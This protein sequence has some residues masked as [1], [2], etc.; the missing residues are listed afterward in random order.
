MNPYLKSSLVLALTGLAALPPAAVAESEDAFCEVR[1]QGERAGN[2]SGYCTV[3]LNEE[4]ITI[5]LVNGASVD[6]EPGERPGRFRDQDGKVVDHQVK[7]D[8]SHYYTW[9][10]KDITVYFN[11]AEGLYN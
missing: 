1:E 2:A 11:R 8:G 5:R 10:N 6:L 9:E 3:S 7:Q 4:F